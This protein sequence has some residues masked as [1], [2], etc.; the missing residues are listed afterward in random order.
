M[1]KRAIRKAGKVMLIVVLS[2]LSVIALVTGMHYTILG[3]VWLGKVTHPLI[4]LSA[5]ASILVIC[6][7][8]I[9]YLVELEDDPFDPTSCRY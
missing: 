5:L 7:G 2:L 9:V 8:I 4:A 1:N 3:L 6:I